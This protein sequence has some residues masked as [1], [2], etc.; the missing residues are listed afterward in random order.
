M[1]IARYDI[2]YLSFHCFQFL[3]FIL[4]S[5][6]FFNFGFILKAILQIFSSTS[7]STKHDNA[8][9]IH[10]IRILYLFRSKIPY[11]MV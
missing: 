2:L 9:A 6:N 5:N 3:S 8:I 7:L 10:L 4:I 11:P 1:Y